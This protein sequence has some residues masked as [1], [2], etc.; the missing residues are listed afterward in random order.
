MKYYDVSRLIE[1]DMMVY[2]DREAKRPSL[3]VIATHAAQG[4]H[5][6]NMH[7]NLHTGT[8]L[9][10]PLHMIDGGKTIDQIDL[11]LYFGPA[12]VFDLTHVEDRIRPA[13]LEGLDIQ[14]GDR[15]LFKTRNSLNDSPA[16]D[17]HFI[18]V[19]TE[20]AAW[21]RDHSIRTLG[22]DAPSIERDQPDHP[23]HQIILG[24]GIGVIEDLRLGEVPQGSYQL[25]CLPLKLAG[26]EA[27]PV[28]AILVA[29]E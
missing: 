1:H 18:F 24:D 3:E 7:Q 28:R 19:S 22:L 14:P 4:M 26:A 16:Y 21:L 10:A 13:D 20:A 25:Y 5:E 9:D 12:K 11:E 17:P 15:V 6:S 8:H 2:K 27:S 29:E 23:V